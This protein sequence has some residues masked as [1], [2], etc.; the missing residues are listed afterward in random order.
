MS[1]RVVVSEEVE[2]FAEIVDES[3][4]DRHAHARV[5]GASI[6]ALIAAHAPSLAL[7]E[8]WLGLGHSL[9]NAGHD[10]VASQAGVATLQLAATTKAVHSLYDRIRVRGR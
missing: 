5:E 10:A 8:V 1:K 9:A 3:A 7:G 6:D 4:A 2:V